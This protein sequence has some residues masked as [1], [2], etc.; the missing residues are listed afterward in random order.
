MKVF[1]N[2]KAVA[3]S[4]KRFAIIHKPRG[5]GSTYGI[6]I[7]IALLLGDERNGNIEV[8]VHGLN[9]VDGYVQILKDTIGLELIYNRL[10]HYL[11]QISTG[12]TIYFRAY[13]QR[14]PKGLLIRNK[15]LTDLR[16]E[17]LLNI[18]EPINSQNQSVYI[19]LEDDNDE[20][21]YFKYELE[22]NKF[23]N[24]DFIST[25]KEFKK[26]EYKRFYLGII[27]D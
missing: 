2:Q 11:K 21:G 9:Q 1:K 3:T 7:R 4:Q 6:C 23:L 19:E 5:G 27:N 26:Q 25:L 16:F 10:E 17:D 13:S 12:Q 15:F 8:V 20:V 14:Q 18:Q 24:E 22:D